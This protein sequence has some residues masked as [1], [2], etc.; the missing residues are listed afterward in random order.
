MEESQGRVHQGL[1]IILKD[2]SALYPSDSYSQGWAF[3]LI[4]LSASPQAPWV[5]PSYLPE[6]GPLLVLLLRSL[7]DFPE[8]P[9]RCL[10]DLTGQ[11][12]VSG[13]YLKTYISGNRMTTT[14]WKEPRFI[15][16]HQRGIYVSLKP[17][18]T[19]HLNRLRIWDGRKKVSNQQYTAYLLKPLFS[20]MIICSSQRTGS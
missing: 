14:S 11:N 12:C 15:P 10:S 19:K 5:I 13:S 20:W 6:R 2:L 3:V 7:V 4:V 18:A 9:S 1:N 16:W 17:M 8:S